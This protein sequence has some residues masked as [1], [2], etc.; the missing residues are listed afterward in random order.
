MREDFR[1]LNARFRELERAVSGLRREVKALARAV[2][3]KSVRKDSSRES[4]TDLLGKLKA[5]GWFKTPRTAAEIRMQLE[6]RGFRYD[7]TDLTHPLQR[8]AKKS[9]LY[10][11]RGKGNW[12]YAAKPADVRDSETT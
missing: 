5:E 2:N 11:S 4:I 1:K 10:R 7:R 12:L 6:A 8:A 3:G 9:L